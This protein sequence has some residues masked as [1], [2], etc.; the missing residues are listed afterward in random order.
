MYCVHYVRLMK[1]IKQQTRLRL[2]LPRKI[3]R[4][5]LGYKRDR[6]GHEDTFMY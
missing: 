1:W 2:V 6:H 3:I 5:P 4:L